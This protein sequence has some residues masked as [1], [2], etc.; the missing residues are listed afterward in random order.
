MSKNEAILTFIIHKEDFGEFS[1]QAVL[2]NQY[3]DIINHYGIPTTDP[4]YE[5][6]EMGVCSGTRTVKEIIKTIEDCFPYIT[7]HESGSN[8]VFVYKQDEFNRLIDDVYWTADGAG[9]FYYDLLSG[10]ERYKACITGALGTYKTDKELEILRYD[11]GAGGYWERKFEPNDERLYGS[12]DSF[13]LKDDMTGEAFD[14][15]GHLYT[16]IFDFNFVSLK[17][18]LLF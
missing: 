14:V 17:D 5:V 12:D 6:I 11:P 15:E 4:I 3:V 8:F 1:G 9:Y 2:Y 16:G 13:F 10:E 7:M 18:N